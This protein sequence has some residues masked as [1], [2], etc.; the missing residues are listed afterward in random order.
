MRL[1]RCLV[2]AGEDGR[3]REGVVAEERGDR[4][5]GA[6]GHLAG[7]EGV[8]VEGQDV[9]RAGCSYSSS[10]SSSLAKMAAS[11]KAA[12]SSKG[13]T[14]ALFPVANCAT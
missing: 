10:I 4:R 13:E 9:D 6:G 11:G 3:Q 14:T 8:A 5:V 12:P 7:V 1:G 2:E